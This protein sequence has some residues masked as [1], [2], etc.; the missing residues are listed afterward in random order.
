MT[1]RERMIAVLD[2]K[3]PDRVPCGLGGCETAGL[4]LLAYD[5]LI[6]ILKLERNPPRLDTFML[7]TVFE[8]ELIEA[9]PGDIILLA[10]PRM[11]G[12]RL[13]GRGYEQEWKEQIL[14]GKKFRVSVRERFKVNEDGSMIWVS[15]GNLRCPAGGIYFDSESTGDFNYDFEVPSPDTF[16]PPHQLD[17]KVLY[18][19][20]AAAKNLY[21]ETALCICAGETITDLQVQPAG[22]IGTMM[23]MKQEPDIMHEYLGKSIESG[24]AQLKQ[25]EQAIGKYVNILSI[26]HDFGDNKGVTIGPQL[27]REIYKPYYQRLFGEWKKITKMKINLH[28]CGS[29]VEILPDLIE[30]GIDIYNP[31]QTSAANMDSQLLKERFG[32]NL[33]FYGGAYD[34]QKV[35]KNA[36]YDTV[37]MIVKNNLEVF[38]QGGRYIFA[39]VHNLPGDTPKHHLEAMLDAWRDN[40]DY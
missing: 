13:W 5:K 17:E 6:E 9:I 37:Y 4:H 24:L 22:F 31:V 2:G 19:L 23:L 36:D 33:I 10:S 7:N 26:A 30:C 25:L 21:E 8:R 14:W 34:A 11:C 20:E 28:S 16:N 15:A 29:I 3:I 1:S 12:S 39:G 27:W 32:E 40:R 35:P 38:K 18:D